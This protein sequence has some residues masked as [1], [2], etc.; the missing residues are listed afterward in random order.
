MITYHAVGPVSDVPRGRLGPN[1]ARVFDYWTSKAAGR[2]ALMRR[3]LDPAEI[4][5]ALPY[6]ILWDVLEGGASIVCRLA[7]TALCQMA[8]RELQGLTV[9]AI[10]WDRPDASKLEWKHVA[11]TFEFDYVERRTQ[12]TEKRTYRS[13]S[14]LLL[15]LAGFS[16]GSAAAMLLSIA[17][18]SR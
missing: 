7:G 5:F 9:E 18:L 1:I 3:D 4:P 16:E 11:T 14:R 15:P 17:D 8:G 6:L 10:H 2:V 13:Y 12:Y